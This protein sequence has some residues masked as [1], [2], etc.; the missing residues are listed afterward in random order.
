VS[1]S[2]RFSGEF[3]ASSEEAPRALAHRV[4][5]RPGPPN[6]RQ[7]T[8]RPTG[9]PQTLGS[10]APWRNH[11]AGVLGLFVALGEVTPPTAAA[12]PQLGQHFHGKKLRVSAGLLARHASCHLVCISSGFPAL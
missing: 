10:L 11:R 1:D 5:G 6:V 3:L 9:K 12:K 8:G 7:S 2:G 4:D